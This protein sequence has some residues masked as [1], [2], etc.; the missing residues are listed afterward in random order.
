[1]RE[2]RKHCPNAMIF[3]HTDDLL[4]LHSES[5]LDFQG[6]LVISPYPL[7]GLNQ[8]W[9]YP[10]KGDKRRIQF[11]TYS[12]QGTYN[13]TLVLLNKQGQTPEDRIIEDRMLEYGFPLK[14]YEDGENR[15]PALWLSIVGRNGIWPVKIFDIGTLKITEHF[16]WPLRRARSRKVFHLMFLKKWEP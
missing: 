14:Q 3:I 5:N 2:I 6:A 8:L 12:S 1:M 13:A 16:G 4:Y 7:F 15:Y 9:T 11:S 10:F